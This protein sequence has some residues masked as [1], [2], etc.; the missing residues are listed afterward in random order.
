[1]SKANGRLR[2]FRTRIAAVVLVLNLGVGLLLGSFLVFER[3]QRLAEAGAAAQN[4]ADLLDRN[5]AARIN[6]IDLALQG[7]VDDFALQQQGRLR[8][9]DRD[10][11][12][13]L[14][15]A[16]ERL[17][18]GALVRVGDAQGNLTHGL[19][20]VADPRGLLADRDYFQR[21]R[22]DPGAGLVISKPLQGK[23]SRTW[24]I[25]FA[26]RLAEQ[27][28]R[29]AGVVLAYMPLEHFH[30]LLARV[31]AGLQG[32]VTWRHRDLAYMARYPEPEGFG[33]TIG[34]SNTPLELLTLIES[35]TPFGTFRTARTFDGIE[36]I[37]AIRRSAETGFYAQ[38]ALSVE[39]RLRDWRRALWLSIVGWGGF[40][41]LSLGAA[42]VIHREWVSRE[43][44]SRALAEREQLLRTI[45]DASSVAIFL[46]D[47]EGRIVHANQRMARMFGRS[48]ADLEG[49]EYVSLIHPDERET[50]RH[51]MRQLMA[52]EI[53]EVDLER[54]YWRQDGS[55]FWGNLT[56]RRLLDE[57]GR[58]IGLLGVIADI[59]ERK[60]IAAEL[61][62]Q[63]QRLEEQVAERTR[64]LAEAKEAAEI[65]NRAKSAFLANMSHEIRTPMNAILGSAYLMRR[66]GVTAGQ[67]A[68]LDRID[69]AGRHLLRVLNDILDISKIEADRLQLEE[70]DLA[71]DRVL[72]DVVAM[73]ADQAQA[74]GLQVR[75]EAA[76]ASRPLRGDPTRLR[77]ALLNYAINA[78]KFTDRGSVT[79]RQEAVEEGEGW[80]L[81]RFEVEDTGIGIPADVLPRLFNAFQQADDSTTREYG[82]TGLGLIITRRLAELMGGEAGVDS[83]PGRG[84]TFWFTARLKT[85][86]A[87]GV[88]PVAVAGGT[89]P[90]ALIAGEFAGRRI[91]LVEDEPMNR[92][93]AQELLEEAGLAIDVA[94]NGAIAVAKAGRND[95]ALIL[96]DMQMPE[97]DGLEATR[98]IRRQAGGRTVP[99]IAMTANAFT[100]DRARCLAAGMDDFIGKPIDPDLLFATILHWLRVG[101]VPPTGI[102]PVSGA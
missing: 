20:G 101:V 92:L 47:M 4:L 56:G 66:G 54:H 26:R 97:M 79:L 40:L 37:V 57:E 95:Y 35:G 59:T 58:S 41:V 93:I 24:G 50:G 32:T 42:G 11:E 14:A 68:Q 13:F 100:D 21:L 8:R 85:G 1:M 62:R 80:A 83:E 72:Q 19:V 70:T 81:L 18:G 22:D 74:K 9:S 86:A 45:Y 55:T 36:R 27:D 6:L 87:Q 91:L 15:V 49:A 60:R 46:V 75:V 16:G 51:K 98:R 38:V 84:S 52:S 64:Q 29:F 102:E 78:V 90:E 73:I 63:N 61:D 65:A 2:A 67:E 89:P 7:V 12:A 34:R 30:Q 96:M 3:G 43:K 99:I 17:G 23:V 94:D 69:A 5:L 44:G 25:V 53:D 28:G 76:P 82:G 71:I 77:Q 88:P 31:D 48:L 39:E 33:S 10:Y